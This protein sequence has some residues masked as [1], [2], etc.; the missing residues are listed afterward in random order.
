MSAQEY[1]GMSYEQLIRHSE[2][3]GIGC[4]L[5]WEGCLFVVKE[6]DELAALRARIAELESQSAT[7]TPRQCN[8][9]CF[10]RGFE[11]GRE[12]AAGAVRSLSHMPSAYEDA[13]RAIAMQPP[14]E[15]GCN[16]LKPSESDAAML[17]EWHK[18]M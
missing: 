5:D 17:D 15:C 8:R 18:R 4:D 3:N 14:A 10:E 7:L 16:P 6:L 12:A 1:G 9:A 2:H 13:I 11:A